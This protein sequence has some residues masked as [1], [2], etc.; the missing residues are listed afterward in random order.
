MRMTSYIVN[1]WE[2][3]TEHT[4]ENFKHVIIKATTA[5]EARCIFNQEFP[6]CTIYFIV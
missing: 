5:S 1:Y 6:T 2:Y 4:Q 3:E